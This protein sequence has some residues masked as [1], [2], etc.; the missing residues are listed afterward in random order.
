MPA[1]RKPTCLG[2]VTHHAPVSFG[3][4]A[5]RTAHSNMDFPAARGC[6][7]LAAPGLLLRC[8]SE[9]VRRS[10]PDDEESA[11]QVLA[12]TPSA[13][14]ATHPAE[15]EPGVKL[16]AALFRLGF[17][18]EILSRNERGDGKFALEGP[19]DSFDC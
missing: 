5:L 14:G 9:R 16:H 17:A 19:V 8:H 1:P 15:Y 2:Q 12:G 4:M 13:V 3:L 10:R 6:G 11:V 18:Q 7:P